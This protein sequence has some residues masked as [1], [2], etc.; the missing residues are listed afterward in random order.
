MRWYEPTQEQLED[1]RAWCDSRPASVA[2]VA[3]RLPPWD[4]FLMASGH[5]CTVYSYGEL[6]GGGVSLTVSVTGR[7][8]RVAFSRNVF[9]IDPEELVPCDLPRP[10]EDLGETLTQD[11]AA[12]FIEQQRKGMI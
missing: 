11:E 4:L 3:R 9:G 7:F 8:N 1:W 12:L 10:E 2:E 5:R 6:K